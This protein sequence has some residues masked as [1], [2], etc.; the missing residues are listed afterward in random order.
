LDN[1][2]T[3][4]DYG[5]P[6]YDRTHVFNFNSVME[7]PFGKGK[8]FL[9]QGG[10]INTIFGGFQL[11]TILQMSSGAP[12]GVLDPRGTLNRAGRSG[13][14]SARSNLTG[15]E[16]KDL[17]GVFKTPNGVFYINPSVLFA[18]A[19]QF[20]AAGVA[21]PGTSR[22]VDLTQTLDPGFRVTSVRGAAAI[23]QPT[24]PGQVFFFNKA[25]ET[26]NLARNFA[27]G[28]KYINLNLNI[29]KNFRFTES[30]RLQIRGEI[31]NALNRPNFS[32]G[33]FDITG[34]QFGRITS[35]FDQRIVQFGAR[36]D[37]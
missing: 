3:R 31:F 13:R 32:F 34:T 24:F 4:L 23:D 16:L 17:F 37:F 14:Q 10:I 20:T 18:T 5:R 1:A 12:I 11:S 21:I 33:D 22:T 15:D 27:N 7:L 8:R 26:G 35:T 36:F 29:S 28:P 6:D 19:Q 25:G 9:N 30:M 2:N